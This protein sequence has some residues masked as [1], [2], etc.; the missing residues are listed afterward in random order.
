MVSVSGAIPPRI[1]S[2][3]LKTASGVADASGGG[4]RPGARLA[5]ACVM[6]ENTEI[7]SS[8][9]GSPTA[10]ERWMVGSRLCPGSYSS[11]RKSG[12]TSEQVGIL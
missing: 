3:A 9:G 11:T 6:A 8:S 5:S 12:G 4:T 10:F 1:A 2:A 7:A